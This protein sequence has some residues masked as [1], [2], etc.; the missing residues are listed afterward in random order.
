M[1]HH[2]RFVYIAGVK[3]RPVPMARLVWGLVDTIE[4]RE[5]WNGVEYDFWYELLEGD[6]VLVVT[7]WV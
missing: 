2:L 6:E 3:T 1:P 7:S 4:V 5:G